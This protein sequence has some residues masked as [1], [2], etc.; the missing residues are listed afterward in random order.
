[1]TGAPWA[2]VIGDPIA[3]SKSPAIHGFWLAEL[4]L[5]GEFRATRVSPA[6]LAD[7]LAARR[8]D[9][10]WRGCSVTIPHKRAV[11]DHLDRLT[12]AAESVGAVNCIHRDGER[13][14]G[15]NT[16][17]DGVMAAIDLHRAEVRRPVLI[18]AGGA[19]RAALA[20][21]RARGARDLAIVARDGAA[22]LRLADAFAL[23][24]RHFSFDHSEGALAGADFMIQATP[25]GMQ[26]MSPLPEAL[27]DALAA[28]DGRA[29]VFDMVYAPLE[30]ELLRRAGDLAL[31]KVNGLTMLVGQARAAFRL[32]FG[33]EPPADDAAPIAR[34]TA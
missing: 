11:I 17:V 2:E 21:L 24:A 1:M 32:F 25:L 8:A 27:L 4:G 26:G 5:P 16:D 28:V 20:A 9:P 14:V 31:R 15:H 12:D 10:A 13:L 33:A 22:A 23:S 3:Q 7:F 18:G 19:A 29:V 34:L 30:T 6:E